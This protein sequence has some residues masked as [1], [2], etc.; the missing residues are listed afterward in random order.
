[1]INKLLLSVVPRDKMITF[2]A[3][4]P[5]AIGA[6]IE[7]VVCWVEGENASHSIYNYFQ[8]QNALINAQ[9]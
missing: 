9:M 6:K 1:M 4:I 7:I 2:L 8:N 5:Y 3:G